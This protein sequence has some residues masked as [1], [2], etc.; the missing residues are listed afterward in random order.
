[1]EEI[2]YSGEDFKT[3]LD[4][5][6]MVGSIVWVFIENNLIMILLVGD[7]GGYFISFWDMSLIIILFC[8]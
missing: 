5:I 1:M 8:K 3:E 6:C 2:E 7:G 4:I